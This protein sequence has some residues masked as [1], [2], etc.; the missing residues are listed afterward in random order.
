MNYSKSQNQY[1]KVYRQQLAREMD[2][3]GYG[4][5]KDHALTTEHKTRNNLPLSLL[6]LAFTFALLTLA[7]IQI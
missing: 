5:A 7:S 6:V 1:L 2:A 4:Q 3:M